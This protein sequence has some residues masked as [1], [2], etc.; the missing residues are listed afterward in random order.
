MHFMLQ[1]RPRERHEPV[2]EENEDAREKREK[3]GDVPPMRFFLEF[4]F[5][6]RDVDPHGLVAKTSPLFDRLLP[7]Y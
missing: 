6:P 4:V 1:K 3:R 2:D 7:V 5:V